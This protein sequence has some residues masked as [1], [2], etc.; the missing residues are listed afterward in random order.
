[1]QGELR[2]AKQSVSRDERSAKRGVSGSERTKLIKVVRMVFK[3]W[4]REGKLLLL[5]IW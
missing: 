2:C 3:T 1:M 5:F 4:S